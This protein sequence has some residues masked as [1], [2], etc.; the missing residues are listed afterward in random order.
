MLVQAVL[1]SGQ[2]CRSK[3]YAVKYWGS[4]EENSLQDLPQGDKQNT[5]GGGGGRKEPRL[6]FYGKSLR[7]S[8]CPLH[9]YLT[10]RAL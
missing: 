6:G 4:A 5:V 9:H 2:K 8:T 10:G 1:F 3:N 7:K